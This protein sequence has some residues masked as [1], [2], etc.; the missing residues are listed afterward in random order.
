MEIG[1]PMK[2]GKEVMKPGISN[3]FIIFNTSLEAYG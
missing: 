1:A 3:K 2:T